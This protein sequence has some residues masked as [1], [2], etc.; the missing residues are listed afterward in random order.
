MRRDRRTFRVSPGLVIGGI[1]LLLL[2]FAGA[3]ASFVAPHDPAE[4]RLE[5][6]LRPPSLEHPLGTDKFGRC[7]LSR[8]IHG[9]RASVGLAAMTTVLCVG[10]GFAL[11]APAAFSRPLDNVLMRATDCLFAF[12]GIVLALVVIGILGPG[13][14]SLALAMVIPGWPKYARLIRAVALSLKEEA[15]VESARA[16]GAGEWTILVRHILPGVLPTVLSV[17]TIGVG[18]KIAMIAGLGFLGLGVQPPTPE[19]GS[20][21]QSGLQLLGSAPHLAV[22]T[23]MMIVLTVLFF[24]LA[25]EGLQDLLSPPRGP[26]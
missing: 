25:G 5:Q 26:R 20:M 13:I 17:A 15:F 4:Q 23:G 12:P 2:A 16:I 1:G 21:M 11:G 22:F 6:Q 3:T 10:I 8:L 7:L 19:W 18:G 14:G 24:T 9:I